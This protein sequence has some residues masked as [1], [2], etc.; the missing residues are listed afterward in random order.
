MGRSGAE[1]RDWLL[2]SDFI[3]FVLEDLGSSEWV[4][5]YDRF[6]QQGNRENGGLF[7][8]VLPSRLASRALLKPSTDMTFAHDRPS[9]YITNAGGSEVIRYDRFGQSE[10]IEPFVIRRWFNDILPAYRELLEEF[11]LFHNLYHDGGSPKY[12]MLDSDGNEHVIVRVT[13]ERIEVRLHQLRQFLALK[14]AHLAVYFD[15]VRNST[16]PIEEIE[17]GDRCTNYIDGCTRYSLNVSSND[18]IRDDYASF[19]RVLGKRLIPPLPKERSGMWP[20]DEDEERFESFIIGV[21]ESGDV[22]ENTCDPDLLRNNFGAN[23]G[24]PHY[25][26]PVFFRRDVL[27][28]YYGAPSK[29]EVHDNYLSCGDL[30]GLRMDNN[31]PTYVVVFLG[32]LGTDVSY[33]EQ[34][35]WRSFNVPPDGGISTVTFDRSILAKFTDPDRPDLL[36]KYLYDDVLRKWPKEWGWA[37]FRTLKPEDEHCLKALHVP[38]TDEQREFDEQ[39]LNLTKLLVDCLNESELAS[40]AGTLPDKPRGIDKLEGF[41]RQQGFSSMLKHIGFLR[42]LQS[43]RSS[44]VAHLKG[45]KY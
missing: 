9:C 34:R 6:D 28:K 7:T 40:R 16:L 35:Y 4:V 36:F 19:S 44:G 39:V 33:N 27:G 20:Y 3:R 21:T 8:A 1:E 18:G 31:H 14:D 38:L 25:L 42:D 17:E 5:V 12:L 32:D 10:G 2:Q 22:I 37:L 29:Y 30:W 24:A 15:R 41:F 11:R 26:T 23:P 43:L 45:K 13:G